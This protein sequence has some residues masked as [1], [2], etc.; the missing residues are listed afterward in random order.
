MVE[1]K[2]N[3][4]PHILVS[5]SSDGKKVYVGTDVNTCLLCGKPDIPEG[6]EICYSCMHKYD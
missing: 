2:N 4:T 5:E 3:A 1:N 6:T